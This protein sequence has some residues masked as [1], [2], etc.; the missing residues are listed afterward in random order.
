MKYVDLYEKNA[1]F[2]QQRPALKRLVLLFNRYLPFLF[3]A[4][5]AGFLAY[6]ALSKKDFQKD[7]AYFVFLPL[8]TLVCVSVLRLCIARPRPYSEK[9]AGITPML[10]KKKTG[11]D[12]CPSRHIACAAAISMAF[13]PFSLPIVIFLQGITL[14]LAYTRFSVG[15]HY[16]S[17]LIIGFVLPWLL[18]FLYTVAMIAGV[19]VLN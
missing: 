11:D 12:S 13:L 5:Y 3:A 1:K 16:I 18:Y 2:L 9:G 14:L 17:D 7:M 8:C 19:F 10:A 6:A 15:V 4:F